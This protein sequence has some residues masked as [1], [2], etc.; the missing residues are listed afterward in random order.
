MK[1][2]TFFRFD[3]FKRRAQEKA[4]QKR[5]G[6]YGKVIYVDFAQKSVE[7]E[8]SEEIQ[9]EEAKRHV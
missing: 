8:T 2:M 6:D 1:W 4:P 7:Q 3:K 5:K 9:L